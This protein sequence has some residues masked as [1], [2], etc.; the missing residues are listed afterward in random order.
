M[1]FSEPTVSPVYSPRGVGRSARAVAL[2][3]V[4]ALG[5]AVALGA[6]ASPSSTPSEVSQAGD[7][8]DD[9]VF[10]P[11]SGES[12]AFTVTVPEGWSSATVGGVTTYTDKLNSIS[13]EQ[14]AVS[15]APTVD[16][17][18]ADVVPGLL[19]ARTNSAGGEATAFTAKG[20]DGIHVAFTADSAADPVTGKSRPDAVEVYL[21]WR[22]G[23]QV[24]LTL[25]GPTT[26]DNVDPWRI[27]S[28]SFTWTNQ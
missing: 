20:G 15:A 28:D 26:A 22:A 25:E 24:A 1:I 19:A 8:P 4:L 14:T 16:S 11:V 2:S 18:T 7:I 10:V 13:I 17:V 12:G 3:L 9:Q 21:F 5:V 6:C 27:V 23:Q